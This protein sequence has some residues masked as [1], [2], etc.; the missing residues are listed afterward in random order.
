[1][2]PDYEKLCAICALSVDYDADSDE[3]RTFFDL[4]QN[5]LHHAVSGKTSAE[6]IAERAD[7][8]MPNMGLTAWKGAE[9]CEDDVTLAKNYLSKEEV[10][11]FGRLITLFLDYADGQARRRRPVFHHHWRA[12]LDD[13][14]RLN[15]QDILSGAGQVTDAVAETRAREQYALFCEASC[16]DSTP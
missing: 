8:A 13:F 11:E 12:K 5:K 7:A 14:L 6:L 10:T 1:M 15:K 9:P 16:N 4:V 3:T 2:N